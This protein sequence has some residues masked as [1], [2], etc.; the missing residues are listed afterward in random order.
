MTAFYDWM[1]N[2]LGFLFGPVMYAI[3]R[4]VNNYGLAIILFTFFCRL[5]MLPTAVSQQKNMAKSQRMQFK[6]RKIQERYK[7]DKRRQQEETQAFYRREGYNP[8]SAGCSA[9]MVIQFPI[10]FGLIAAIYRPLQYT[11]RIGKEALA[12][13]RSVVE[14]GGIT[15]IKNANRLG[16]MWQLQVVSHFKDFSKL[17]KNGKLSLSDAALDKLD[18]ATL[19]QLVGGG[20][21]KLSEKTVQAIDAATKV[22]PAEKL[23]G[24]KLLSR[25]LELLGDKGFDALKAT[26]GEYAVG[27]VMNRIEAFTHQFSLGRLDLGVVPSEAKGWYVLIPILAGLASMSTSLYTYIRS[28][29]QNPEQSKNPM[30]GCMTFGMPLFSVFLAFGFPTG[31]AIYWIVSSLIA[32]LQL[33]IL[34]NTHKPAKMLARVMVEETILRRSRENSRRKMSELQ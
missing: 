11:V 12:V 24:L 26:G 30:M 32:F 25:Q 29:K 20:Q 8:M 22:D 33:L 31:V 6:L 15:T 7:D 21:L 19:R 10:I 1:Y 27:D 3:F 2:V 14:T 4:V 28:R 13:I 9:S 23:T 34:S 16:S 18:F 5:L 17:V